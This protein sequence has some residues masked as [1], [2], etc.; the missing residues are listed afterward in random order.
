MK[1]EVYLQVNLGVSYY[2]YPAWIRMFD[3]V[4]KWRSCLLLLG[5]LDTVEVAFWSN[6]LSCQVLV[7]ILFS[8]FSI[9][10]KQTVTD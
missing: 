3:R 5:F 6:R 1:G 7:E 9:F 4:H 2:Q 10:L 8:N